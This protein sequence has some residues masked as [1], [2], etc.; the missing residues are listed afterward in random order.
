MALSKLGMRASSQNGSGCTCAFHCTAMSG[1]E[2]ADL[3]EIL[4]KALRK[5]GG[6]PSAA[7]TKFAQIALWTAVFLEIQEAVRSGIR[8]HPLVFANPRC[9]IYGTVIRVRRQVPANMGAH[10]RRKDFRFGRFAQSPLSAVNFRC[11]ALFWRSL[12]GAVCA[13][14]DICRVLEVLADYCPSLRGTR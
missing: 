3:S 8:R 11:L 9:L 7:Q 6:F 14:Y 13:M 4:R 10:N 1:E 5:P 2:V 12:E